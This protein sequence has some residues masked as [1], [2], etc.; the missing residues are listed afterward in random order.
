MEFL[1]FKKLS[2]AD[3]LSRLIPKFS[4]PLEDTVIASLKA[5]KE[6]KDML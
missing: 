4:L 1:P 2:H 6:V 3:G 5:K